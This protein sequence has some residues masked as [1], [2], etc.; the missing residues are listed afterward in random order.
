V[1]DLTNYKS[2]EWFI[3]LVA[4]AGYIKIIAAQFGYHIPDEAVDATLNIVGVIVTLGG[5]VYKT[6]LYDKIKE[7]FT[8]TPK[9]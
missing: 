6:H 1:D 8:K 9:A 2:T 7:V 4:L 3:L 5:I